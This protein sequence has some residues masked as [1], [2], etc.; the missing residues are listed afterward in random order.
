MRPTT[1]TIDKTPTGLTYLRK[2]ILNEKQSGRM[3]IMEEAGIKNSL[4]MY[5]KHLRQI[6]K[7]VSNQIFPH[8]FKKIN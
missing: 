6:N 7:D 4:C 3:K 5:L 8:N 2:S 1:Y